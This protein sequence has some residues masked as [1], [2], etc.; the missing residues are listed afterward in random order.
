MG[1][2]TAE[3]R[4]PLLAWWR[5]L[6]RDKGGRAALRRCHTLAEVVLVPAYHEL[7]QDLKQLPEV[8]WNRER[9]PAVAALVAMVGEFS[10]EIPPLP[11]QMARMIGDRKLVSELRFRRLLQCQEP[12]DLFQSLR[13]VVRLLDRR[14]NIPELA[15]GIHG[16]GDSIRK[17]WAYTYYKF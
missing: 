1:R 14:V 6:E 7:Y 11:E 9:L 15:A 16:W 12:E 2:F 5:G 10:H 3:G 17:E 8:W 4:E 13:R